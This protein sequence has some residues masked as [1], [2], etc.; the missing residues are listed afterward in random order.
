MN[1]HDTVLNADE[2]AL[3]QSNLREGEELLWAGRSGAAA[4]VVQAVETPSFWRRIFGG[5]RSVLE[6][7]AA[8]G[9]YAV[10]AITNKRVLLL[11]P[12][13]EPQEWFLMLGMIRAF[14]SQPSGTGSIILDYEL[15]QDG[16]RK[17]IGL[18]NIADAESVHTLLC[19]AIDAAYNA[20]PWSV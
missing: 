20:S 4:P 8:P 15:A 12:A 18:L 11:P 13:G 19:S 9:E 1:I 14:E 2:R 5:K 17:P 7:A 3:L 6:Q 10:G 16:E